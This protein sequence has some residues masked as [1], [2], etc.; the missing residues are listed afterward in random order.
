MKNLSVLLLAVILILSAGNAFSDDPVEEWVARYTSPGNYDDEAR[1]IALDRDGNVYVTGCSRGSETYNDYATIKYNNDGEE[2]W[3]ARYN[4]FGGSDDRAYAIAVDS[5]GNVYV[6]GSSIGNGTNADCATIKYNNDGVEQW[7]TRY[8]S[9]A[10]YDDYCNSIV[11]DEA[12]NVYVTGI[13]WSGPG[14]HTSD[15]LTI[16]YNND[17]VEQWVALYNGPGNEDDGA[18]AISIDETGN[19]YVTGCSK[20]DGTNYD[21]AT[22]KYNNDGV[23]QWIARYNGGSWSYDK[24]VAISIDETG[25]VY[26]TGCSN[27]GDAYLDYLTIKYNSAGGEQWIAPYDGPLNSHDEAYGIVVDES[28]NVYVT[29]YSRGVGTEEDYTTIKYNSVG[30]EEWVA[31]DDCW[32]L[33]DIATDIAIDSVGN[34]YV[35]GRQTGSNGPYHYATIKYNPTGVKQWIMKYYGP[36]GNNNSPCAIEVDG[37]GN[38]YVTGWSIDQGGSDYA[39]IKYHQNNLGLV[40]SQEITHNGIRLFP[41]VP[42]PSTNMFTISY[43][44]PDISEV[45]VKIYDI[46]GILVSELSCGEYGPGLHQ[47]QVCDIPTGVYFCRLRAGSVSLT[48]SFV[49]IQY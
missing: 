17:G 16:K 12:G 18:A 43:Y 11:L 6:T 34:V 48:K 1:S 19:V 39:T 14:I 26:V 29:G 22:I 27:G 5:S 37:S 15:Y 13:S 7:V 35:T 36:I 30:V 31:R 32:D 46:S 24:A 21:Y 49:I 4:N 10:N 8:N 47:F 40:P 3:C 9:P 45:M 28:H 2:I 20:G 23:E 38:V 25:N 33:S 44:I 41:I 42:N